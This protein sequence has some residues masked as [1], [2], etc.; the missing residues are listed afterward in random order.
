MEDSKNDD[1]IQ[2]KDNKNIN[3]KNTFESYLEKKGRNIFVGWQ[4]R[5]FVCLEG[6]IIIYT[7]SKENKNVKG[8]IQIKKICNLKSIDNKTFSIEMDD[9]TYTL[10]ANN[11]ETKNNWM[12]KI[13]YCFTFVK[14]GSLTSKNSSFMENLIF[15]YILKSDEKNKL[16]PISKKLG[17]IILK[18][19]YI[20]NIGNNQSGLNL[21]KHGIDKLINLNDNKILMNIH[22]GFMYKRKRLH[23]IY[24][25]RWFFIFSR[26]CLL[27]NDNNN[28][29]SYLDE[30]K[31]KGWIKFDTLYYFKN[32]KERTD[33][34]GN[35]NVFDAEIKMDE[36]HKIINYD[37]DGKYYM[38][39]DFNERIYEF[40]CESK[41]ERDEWFEVLVNSRAT[42]KT[43]KFSI[44]KQ[45]KNVD[46]LNNLL[47]KDKE[48]F[49]QKINSDVYNVTGD[50]SQISEFDLFEFT[51]QNLE[52]FIEAHMDGCLCSLPIKVELLKEYSE[53]ANRVYINI[54]K[55]FWDKNH[56]VIRKEEIVQL[57][58]LM[59]NYYDTVNK[60]KVNDI[61]LLKN[62]TE[63]IRIYYKSVFPNILYSVEN[64]IKYQIEHKGNKNEDGVY[65]SDGPKIFF[66]I[67]W[68]IFDLV[69]DYKHKIIFKLLLKILNMSIYQYCNGINSVL[70]NRGIIIED[71]YLITVS[72]DS[73]TINELMNGFIGHL[74]D[75]NIL[76]IEEINEEVRLTKI[77]ELL[78]RLSFNAII[79]LLYEHKE[80]LEKETDRQNF[81]EMKI[82]KIIKLSG[83]I[84]AKY[85]SMMNGR[86]RKIFYKEILRLTLCYYITRLLLIEINKK[87]KKEN[88]INKIKNDKEILQDTYKDII[89]ENLTISTLK[90]LDDIID[91]LEVDKN[92]ISTAI[93]TIRQYI[94]PAF[95]YQAAKTLVKFR[96]DLTREEIIECKKQ[97]EEVL[98]KYEGPKGETSSFFQ[99]LNTKLKK[100][101]K[102]K[103]FLKLTES[104]IKFG[105][106]SK[107]DNKSVWIE[108]YNNENSDLEEE[109]KNIEMSSDNVKFCITTNLK[110]FLNDSDDGEE[111]E[112]EEDDEEDEGD[113]EVKKDKEEDSKIDI[114]G[115][116]QKK[117]GSSYKKYY[118]QVKNYGLYWFEDQKKSKPK[119][120]LSLKDAT[121][122]NP[123]SKLTEF[124][125]K[126]REKNVDKEYKFK[127][128]NEQEK[129][130]LVKA[131]T[132][133]INN[134][135]KV[136]NGI[137]LETIEIKER[138]KVIRDYLNANNK[139]QI[140]YIE[141]QIFEY[142]KTGKYFNI[143][144]ERMK[145]QMKINKEKRNKEIEKEKEE[146]KEKENEN[147]KKLNKQMRISTTKIKKKKTIKTKIKNFFKIG[148]KDKNDS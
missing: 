122:L 59:L 2:P 47:I 132:K 105:R 9:R 99:K 73:F 90:I 42:A 23:D 34:E 39:L 147:Q 119:N 21:R 121:L 74:K 87:L 134:S 104:Q 64:M 137:Q 143:N 15:G 57:G 56:N 145:K 136:I 72:N 84:Y 128:N 62:G 76:T 50:I 17:D 138:K 140:N 26:G 35:V 103:N 111:V 36:C 66:D 29:N 139:I 55:H 133:A 10:R 54:F 16:R 19:G 40:Y 101:A 94:G 88:I 81:F 75:L 144:Q 22:Y 93:L 135:K 83:E 18:H 27:N 98:N 14:K 3:S 60:F 33:S 7:E 114:E 6:K 20:L 146:E 13:R 115:F 124:S 43:Y 109:V 44:T 113:D 116:F 45:P 38:N 32:D 71:E 110:E 123:E 142:V 48:N 95:T 85:K 12:E 107:F 61:N 89:G 127:C 148:K 5:Y 37:K 31:Q 125:L 82:E 108:E 4:K 120:K 28:D 106:D 53:Y 92:F 131:M 79:H 100:N 30:K 77:M 91:A 1:L 97:C 41:M 86:V 52:K 8:F 102:D 70:S 63:F 51:A 67:F 69:K 129:Y 80:P 141:D 78:D 65:F 118:Y 11:N 112:E 96:G 24:N 58:L 68:K 46:G 126:L 49:Y 130:N 117:S 25:K